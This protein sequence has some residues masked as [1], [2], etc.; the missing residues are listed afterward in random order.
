MHRSVTNV[1]FIITV[2]VIISVSVT[3]INL[4]DPLFFHPNM[5]SYV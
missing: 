3:V 5:D 1:T 2:I 4:V